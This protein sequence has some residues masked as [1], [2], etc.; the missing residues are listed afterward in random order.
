VSA[1][2]LPAARELDD[3]EAPSPAVGPSKPRLLRVLGPGLITGASDDDPSGIATYGQAGAQLGYGLCWTMLYTLP[4]MAA[5]QMVSARIGRTTGYG[6]AGVLRAHYPN[7]LLQAVVLLLLAANIL[8]LGADLGAMADALNLLLPGPR[9]LYVVL[10]AGTCVFMQV[11]LRYA[12]YVAVLKWLTLSLFAYLGVVIFA[13]VSWRDLGMAM[14]LP[15]LDVSDGSLTTLVALFGTT[16]SPYLFFWQAAE[17]AEDLHAFPRRRDLLHAPEQ[18]RSALRRIRI[19]TLVGMTFSNLVALA[20]MVTA[21]AVLHPNGVTAIQTSSQAAEALRPLAGPFSATVFALG[22]VGTGLLAVPVL[23]GSA[24]YAVG[25]ARRW[26]V[27]FGRRLLE[28]RAFYGT[29]ALA[30]LVGMV[31]SLGAVDPIRALYWS[32]VVNGVIAVPVMAVM[33]LAAARTDVMGAFAV[34]GPLRLL[35]WLATACMLLA[36]LAMLGTAALRPA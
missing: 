31:I 36:V 23:A 14:A 25:E 5:V 16:I 21:A 6:I 17:E 19:D 1:S 27:G 2:A 13:H 28:A 18:G 34:R 10:F 29:V 12:R 4:L 20:I 7:G 3:P 30:T 22:V 26:P 24:A 32:A 33:M 8:N 11:V 9:W 15:R 35:G